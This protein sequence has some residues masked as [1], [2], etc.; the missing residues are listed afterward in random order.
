MITMDFSELIKVSRVDGVILHCPF[1]PPSR[2]DLCITGHHLILNYP[3][4]SEEI[5]VLFIIIHIM[6]ALFILFFQILHRSVDSIQRRSY[7]LDDGGSVIIKC[8]DLKQLKIE[9]SGQEEFLNVADS[10]E[11]LSAIGMYICQEILLFWNHH[12]FC[13]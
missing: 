12:L 8:K 5:R 3:S 7:S 4:G 11:K 10:L 1:Q 2:K 9:I 13:S 6:Y